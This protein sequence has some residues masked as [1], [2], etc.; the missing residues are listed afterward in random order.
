M[1]LKIRFPTKVK[2]RVSECS[3]A[4]DTTDSLRRCGLQPSRLF[5]PWDSPGKNAAMGCCALL[6][7]TEPPSPEL[8]MGSLL[9]SPQRSPQSYHTIQQSNFW[10]FNQKSSSSKRYRDSHFHRSTIHSSQDMETT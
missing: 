2:N 9:L 6:Q 5:S 8:Q 3:I 1:I 7:G 4:L 10:V